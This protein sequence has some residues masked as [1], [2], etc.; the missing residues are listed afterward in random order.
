MELGGNQLRLHIEKNRLYVRVA[1]F[2][3]N[4]TSDLIQENMNFP[5]NRSVLVY[6]Y[7]HSL[8]LAK[9]DMDNVNFPD[10]RL[11]DNST[12]YLCS[13]ELHTI[14]KFVW[15][16]M[17]KSST[18]LD[19]IFSSID[20]NYDTFNT[21]IKE[22]SYHREGSSIS[23]IACGWI[24]RHP[25]IWSRWKLHKQKVTLYIV[26]MFPLSTSDRHVRFQAPAAAVSLIKAVTDIQEDPTILKDYTVKYVLLQG[27]CDRD[28]VLIS[29]INYIQLNDI[30]RLIG[31][32]GP[33]CSDTV[34]PLA[35]VAEQFH[36]PIISYGAEGAIFTDKKEYPYFFRTI[37]ENSIFKYVYHDLFNKMGWRNIG[38]LAE[39]G[40]RYSEYITPTRQILESKG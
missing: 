22:Y 5:D 4:I 26:G 18:S 25:D 39:D 33:A 7:T 34:I 37:P 29:I 23:D 24:N 13:Y 38:S 32:V 28:K 10:C 1:F 20:F 2:G 9:F 14:N 15:R 21:L 30:K 11:G 27:A 19:R 17:R 8:L 36:I 35:G 31:I 3:D 6:H 40:Q 12:E 16:H